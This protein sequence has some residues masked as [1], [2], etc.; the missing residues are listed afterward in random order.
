MQGSRRPWVGVFFR[1]GRGSPLSWRGLSF[2][3]LAL[4]FVAEASASNQW[5]E[6]STYSPH[7][8][9]IQRATRSLDLEVYTISD[10][11]VW[12][13]LSQAVDRGVRVRMVKDAAPVGSESCKILTPPNSKDTPD[14]REIKSIVAKIRRRGGVVAFNKANLCGKSPEANCFEHGKMLVVDREVA[15]V[16]SGNFDPTSLCGLPEDSDD[17][18]GILDFQA[19]LL[20]QRCNRDYSVK[21]DDPTGVS[22]L[23]RVFE[24]DYAGE[25][26]ALSEEVGAAASFLTVSPEAR[27]SLL[28]AL[29]EA[30]E[31]VWIQNQYLKDPEMNSVLTDLARRRVRVNIGVAS[32]CAFGRPSASDRAKAQ[33]TFGAFERLGIKTRIFSQQIRVG[34]KPG[35]LHGKALVIDGKKAWIGSINGSRTAFDFN[36]EFGVFLEGEEQAQ[37]LKRQLQADSVDSGSESW[38][39]SLDCLKDRTDS[40]IGGDFLELGVDL[41]QRLLDQ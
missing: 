30:T 19:A 20:G 14:C 15:L 22:A 32:F 40:Y 6:N 10:L 4:V 39:E 21:V 28:S 25:P 13:A 23:A 35:Y 7:L 11:R 33:D 41:S 12:R 3:C 37:A 31:E 24:R 16:S 38:Q 9:M 5:F 36:R 17:E 34:G 2:G 8:D 26:F 1:K 18:R 27:T 29:S